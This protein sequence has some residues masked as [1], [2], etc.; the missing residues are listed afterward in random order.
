MEKPP[1]YPFHLCQPDAE[2]SCGACC[3]LYN[4]HDHSRETLI[5]FLRRRTSLFF[6]M[7]KDIDFDEYRRLEEISDSNP[8]LLESIYNCEFLGFIDGDDKRVGCLLHPSINQGVNLREYSFYGPELCARH[9][10]PSYAHLTAV[11]Q[12]AVFMAL[13]DWYLYGLVITDIDFVKEFF[14]LVQDRMG[15]SL[16]AERL[17]DRRVRRALRAFFELKES[18]K[19]C[20]PHNRLGKYYFS[21][22][23]YQI[24]RINYEKRWKIKPSKF[25][26]ILVSLS[27][28]FE[29]QK[30]IWEAEGLIEEK[31][32]RFIETYCSSS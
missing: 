24:A 7:G 13:D 1:S 28:D 17:P 15:D 31:I 20:S 8:K 18:W 5:S 30:E 11:E 2:K 32:E 14:R 10:C 26:K 3:G 16:R 25:D 23:E 19:F 9:F 6:S 12:S 29:N 21:H 27:S 22:S 4:R